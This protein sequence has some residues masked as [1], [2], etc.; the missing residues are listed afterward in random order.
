MGRAGAS[1]RWTVPS[2]PIAGL[3]GAPGGERGSPVPPGAFPPLAEPAPAPAEQ[4]EVN[5]DAEHD[6]QHP[7]GLEPS[8]LRRERVLGDRVGDRGRRQE[9]EADGWPE[10]SAERP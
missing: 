1:V 7:T 3:P 5:R 9:E 2:R 4:S 10:P 6:Q 8:A